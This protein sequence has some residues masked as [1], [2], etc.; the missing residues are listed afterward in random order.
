LPFDRNELSDNLNLVRESLTFAVSADLIEEIPGTGEFSKNSQPFRLFLTAV[1][2]QCPKPQMS[3]DASRTRESFQPT[4]LGIG[5]PHANALCPNHWEGKGEPLPVE[6]RREVVKPP[7]SLV[8]WKNRV[9]ILSFA[10][11]L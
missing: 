7:G 1:R 10:R 2:T 8:V 11:R 5:Q 3:R 9:G 6:A 4:K